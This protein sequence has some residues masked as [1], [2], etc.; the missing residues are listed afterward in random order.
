MTFSASIFASIFHRFFID[1]GSQNGP[2]LKS[3]WWLFGDLF[4]TSLLDRF[5]APFWS[6]FGSLWAPF[7]LP[8]APFGLQLVPFGLHLA[9]FWLPFGALGLTFAC[10][11]AKFSYFLDLHAYFHVFFHIFY[12]NLVQNCIFVKL[13]I[14]NTNFL[15]FYTPGA[16]I[17]I[18][19]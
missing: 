15:T 13:F 14:K 4:R 17:Y 7:W 18:Y 16:Y 12:G 1:F 2:F 11:G 10:L 3:F 6:P 19:I 9:S 8:S 5:L